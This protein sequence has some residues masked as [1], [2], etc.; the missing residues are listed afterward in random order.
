MVPDEPATIHQGSELPWPDRY[1][2]GIGVGMLL[3]FHGL[4]V[5]GPLQGVTWMKPAAEPLFIGL[6]QLVYVVPVSILLLVTGCRKTLKVFALGALVTFGL[7]AA[8]CGAFVYIMS[9][10]KW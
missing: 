10:A 2:F 5:F 1:P 8:A 9:Q 7:N 3:V 4:L 6:V